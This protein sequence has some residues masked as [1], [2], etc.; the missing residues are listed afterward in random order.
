M[1]IHPAQIQSIRQALEAIE[2]QQAL[3]AMEREAI[4]QIL[5]RVEGI[6]KPVVRSI[7]GYKG[8]V[9]SWV[10]RRAAQLAIQQ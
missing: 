5:D 3:L 8:K 6:E 9:A 4:R 1:K 7:G 2:R 10:K